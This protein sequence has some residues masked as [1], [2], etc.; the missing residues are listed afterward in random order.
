MRSLDH[1][2]SR[3]I[4][5]RVRC[6]TREA[7]RPPPLSLKAQ[8]APRKPPQASLLLHFLFVKGARRSS[9][10]SFTMAVLW[11]AEL[12]RRDARILP[13]S[14]R[15]LRPDEQEVLIYGD[16]NAPA[17]PGTSE[18]VGAVEADDRRSSHPVVCSV[19]GRT[20]AR[21]AKQSPPDWHARRSLC[22][23]HVQSFDQLRSAADPTPRVRRPPMTGRLDP[24]P[25]PF[26]ATG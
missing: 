10:H 5:R 4:C 21:P 16:E 9:D 17:L 23:G 3:G 26:P 13:P 2:R 8:N 18:S 15:L 25:A 19:V 20:P 22:L 11:P 7:L 14:G 6:P 24:G 12:R 1:R